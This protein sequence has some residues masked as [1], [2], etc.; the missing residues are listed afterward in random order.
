MVE[1]GP[2]RSGRAVAVPVP[3][4]SPPSCVDIR[5]IY[6]SGPRRVAS[7]IRAFW[8]ARGVSVDREALLRDL[9]HFVAIV[10]G[11]RA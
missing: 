3:G 9:N 8:R 1:L 5:C 11:K 2:L 4:S 7:R 10:L 6:L